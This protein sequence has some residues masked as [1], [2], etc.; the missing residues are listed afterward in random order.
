[1]R[2]TDM[3]NKIKT[4][5]LDRHDLPKN[6]FIAVFILLTG[7]GVIFFGRIG[8]FEEERKNALKII[9]TPPSDMMRKIPLDQQDKGTLTAASSSVAGSSNIAAAALSSSRGEGMYLG[10]QSG[11]TYYLP[12]C[13]GAKRIHEDN[14]IWFGNKEAAQEKGY[15]PAKNC[16]GI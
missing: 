11:H 1:M 10:A 8:S 14:K 13:A 7:L 4:A 6:A 3:P 9:S 5:L 2:L 16:K 15:K 12:W